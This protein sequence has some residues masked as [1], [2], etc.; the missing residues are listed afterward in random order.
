M[1]DARA[2]LDRCKARA[3]QLRELA[4]SICIPSISA[5]M[6]DLASRCERAGDGIAPA[7][8]CTVTSRAGESIAAAPDAE[9]AGVARG[10]AI[11]P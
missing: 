2:M 3:L 11:S 7:G 8:C 9:A 5:A 6:L 10:R 4:Q 1:H